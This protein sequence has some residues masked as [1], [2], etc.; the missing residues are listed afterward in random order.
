MEWQVLD[1]NA[2]AIAFYQRLGA[3]HLQGWLPYRLTR[4]ELARIL[5]E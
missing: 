5:A 4:A 2:P 1:W 3:S